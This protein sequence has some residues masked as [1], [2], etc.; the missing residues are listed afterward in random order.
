[1][2][3]ASQIQHA[4]ETA[5]TFKQGHDAVV[6]RLRLGRA[7]VFEVKQRLAATQRKCNDCV[8][9]LRLLAVGQFVAASYLHFVLHET[10]ALPFRRRSNEEADEADARLSESRTFWASVFSNS[11]SRNQ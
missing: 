5:L 6:F 7:L 11:A 2:A 10:N 1:M 8:V 4:I 9:I 3:R